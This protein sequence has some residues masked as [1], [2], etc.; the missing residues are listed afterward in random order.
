VYQGVEGLSCFL[1][2]LQILDHVPYSGGTDFAPS[3][4][5]TGG[6]GQQNFQQQPPQ[7]GYQQQ[8]PQQPPQQGYQQPAPQQGYQQAP[9]QPVPLQQMPNDDLPF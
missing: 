7:Q 6:W 1:E 5:T 9:Q 3:A 4:G 2:G 8:A